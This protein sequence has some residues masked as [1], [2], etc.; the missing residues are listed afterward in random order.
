MRIYSCIKNSSQMENKLTRQNFLAAVAGTSTLLLFNQSTAAQTF[1]PSYKN[2]GLSP[3]LFHQYFPS[4]DPELVQEMVVVS[5]GQVDKV[6]ELLAAHPELAK[7]TWD[8]GYGDWETALGA[9]SH[10]GNKEIA[11]LLMANG[12]RPDIFTFAMLGNLPAVQAM[13]EGNPGVQKIKGPH[14]ITLL[15]HAKIRLASKSMNDIDRPKALAMIDYLNALGDADGK[16]V[17]LDISDLEK[18]KFTG[19]FSFGENP[20]DMFLVDVNDKGKLHIKRPNQKFERPL[21]RVEENSFAPLGA[22]HVKIIF[23][24][25]DGQAMMLSVHDPAPIVKALRK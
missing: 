22:P 13:I 4:Q 1:E 14:G 15:A 24:I 2:Q 5:H 7:A 12:A 6:K 21:L 9:A 18:K 8:F 19:N 11:E 25:K 17:S 16:A 23:E 3:E 20:N 10:T